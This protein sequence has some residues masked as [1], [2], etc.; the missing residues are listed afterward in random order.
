MKKDRILQ[1]KQLIKLNLRV[2]KLYKNEKKN[3]K[4]KKKTIF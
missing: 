1:C 4:K 3:T 2:L